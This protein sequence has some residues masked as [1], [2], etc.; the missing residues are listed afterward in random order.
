M[1]TKSETQDDDYFMKLEVLRDIRQ[2]TIVAEKMKLG[3]KD[4]IDELRREEKCIK[5]YQTEVE[6]LIQEKMAH[7]EELRLIHTDINTME[8][9]AKQARASRQNILGDIQKAHDEFLPL[10]N[11]VNEL[12]STVGVQPLENP[13]DLPCSVARSVPVNTHEVKLSVATEV[14]ETPPPLHSSLHHDGL[15]TSILSLP[16]SSIRQQQPAPMKSCQSCHQLIHRNAPICPLCKAKSRSRN[17]KK[18]KRRPDVQ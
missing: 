8:D 16:K 15:G 18:S 7:V 1:S 5:E 9:L 10:K 3:I 17:P 14:T 4:L 13:E 2:K 12:R 6:L 11:E